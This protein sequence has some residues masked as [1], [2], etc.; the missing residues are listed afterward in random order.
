[1]NSAASVIVARVNPSFHCTPVTKT[2]A[3]VAK[4][5]IALV[6]QVAPPELSSSMALPLSG[7]SFGSEGV[8]EGSSESFEL[9][10]KLGIDGSE[11]GRQGKRSA[12]KLIVFL[13]RDDLLKGAKT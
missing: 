6:R 12:R 10:G 7:L 5:R 4:K 13:D 9:G 8:L 11:I 1:M 2:L 3:T